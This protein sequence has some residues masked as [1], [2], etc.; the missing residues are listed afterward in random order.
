MITKAHTRYKN[1]AGKVIPG[2]TTPLGKVNF[3]GKYYRLIAWA[4]K[5]GLEGIDSSKYRDEAGAVGTLA[6]EMIMADLRGEEVDTSD[7][8]Q[9][10]ID[11]AENCYLKWLE[12]RKDK[13]LEAYQVEL[14]LVSEEYQYG[15]TID[16]LGMIDGCYVVADYKT[17]W[18]GIEAYIQ[19]C[20]Y[21]QLAIENEFPIPEKI[22]ILGIP[23]TED[24]IFKERIYTDFDLGWRAFL[25]AKEV[26]AIDKLLKQGG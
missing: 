21:R 25:A 22:V 24:E 14:S 18:V 20:A 6:H 12:W 3:D 5:K 1:K 19:T 4:N 15:G 23:R 16:Y 9:Q 13:V 26:Y 17:G 7:Y 2:A 10:Q 11:K 8:S